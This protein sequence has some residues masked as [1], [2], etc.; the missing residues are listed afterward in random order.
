MGSVVLELQRD[1]LNRNVSVS[2]LLR[3][4]LV[5]ARKLGLAE[6]Q[7]WIKN[8]LGGYGEAGD[9][10]QY[11]EVTGQVMGWNPYRGWIPVGF[12]DPGD[13]RR[14][15]R[16]R[17]GQSIAELESLVEGSAQGAAFHMP[18]PADHTL[19]LSSGM[20]L[21]TQLSL[22]TQRAA[23]VGI[24]DA[25]R[26]GVLNW[27]I[28][29]KEEGVLGEDLAF[30]AAERATAATATQNV[31]NFY[32][33][34]TGVTVQQ[35]GNDSIQVSATAPD[36]KSLTTFLTSLREALPTLALSK[37][38]QAELSAE[39]ETLDVQAKSPRPKASIIK[40]SLRSVRSIL[41]GAAGAAAGQLLL[42]QVT[43]LLGG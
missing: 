8:E 7:A 18:F 11:R 15:S 3:K 16:R 41:E 1:A 32:A 21:R 25:V 24:I 31:T 26:T 12:D 23:I 43:K 10:P 14:F 2:D 27:A 37:D 6:M 17:C 9:C 4:A 22:F 40:E 34:V 5:V 36:L 13:K 38:D 19:H 20:A 29:L 35:A 42:A 33:P 39:V 28:K 30:S